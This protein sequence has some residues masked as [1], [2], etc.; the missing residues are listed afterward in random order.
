MAPEALSVDVAPGQM[1]A[2]VAASVN[3]GKAL[4]SMFTVPCPLQPL[5]SSPSTVYVVLIVGLSVAGFNVDPIGA[6]V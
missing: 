6:Q 5:A 3:V 1:V 2:G 4:T